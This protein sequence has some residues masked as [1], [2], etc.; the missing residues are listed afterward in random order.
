M[1]RAPL[2]PG[3]ALLLSLLTATPALVSG[4]D[5]VPTAA[6][7]ESPSATDTREDLQRRAEGLR[8]ENQTLQQ[9]LVELE[10]RKTALDA[11]RA[12]QDRKLAELK[13]RLDA[14]EATRDE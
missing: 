14:L 8:A 11:R 12:E 9:R 6:P 10:Q 13:A 3:R 1:L 7:A 5:P 4:A 2:R